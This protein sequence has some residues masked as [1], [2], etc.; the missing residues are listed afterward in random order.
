[1]KRR[2]FIL[3][4]LFVFMTKSY[5]LNKNADNFKIIRDVYNHLFPNT[6]NYSGASIFGALNFLNTISK[7][8]SFDTSDLKLILNGAS[9]LLIL[10]KNFLLLNKQQKEKVL[11]E[12][13]NTNF[14][15]NWLSTLL[16]YGFEAMLGDPIYKGNKNMTGW[17]NI[18]HTIPIPTANYPFG[19]SHD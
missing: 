19:K 11:R 1:M 8:K 6:S 15:Q 3:F 12:F 10:E 13:E 17:K 14:G 16:Y 4:T 7:H 18:K 2:T 5:A 9:K